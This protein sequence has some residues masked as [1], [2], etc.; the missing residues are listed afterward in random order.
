MEVRYSVKVKAREV[1]AWG[2]R[3]IQGGGARGFGSRWETVLLSRECWRSLEGMVR[4]ADGLVEMI[5]CG[6]PEGADVKTSARC[7]SLQDAVTVYLNAYVGFR[8]VP[9][10]RWVELSMYQWHCGEMVWY[11]AIDLCVGLLVEEQ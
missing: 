9:R 4:R 2:R 1:L 6:G 7:G 5:L 8:S 3:Y 11:A 10:Q